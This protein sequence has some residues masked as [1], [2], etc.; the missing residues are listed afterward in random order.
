M[1][2]A[3]RTYVTSVARRKRRQHRKWDK[4]TEQKQKYKDASAVTW[5]MKSAVVK[6][7]S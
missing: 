5:R 1:K 7:Q 4:P 3:A 2:K 6:V